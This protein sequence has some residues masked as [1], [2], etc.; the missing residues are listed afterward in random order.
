MKTGEDMDE[1]V[2]GAM[3]ASVGKSRKG[4]W[5]APKR[6]WASILTTGHVIAQSQGCL[7]VL[8]RPP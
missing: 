1:M 5:G 8:V 2:V 3:S 7:K 4:G 6:G